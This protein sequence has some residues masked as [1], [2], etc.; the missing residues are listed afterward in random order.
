MSLTKF[1]K[2][3]DITLK[4]LSLSARRLTGN[5]WARLPSLNRTAIYAKGKEGGV[6]EPFSIANFASCK[7]TN[8][9]NSSFEKICSC[10]RDIMLI[11]CNHKN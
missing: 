10:W 9:Y 4:S 2:Q 6:G 7:F 3:N 1:T 11:A 5:D 8:G